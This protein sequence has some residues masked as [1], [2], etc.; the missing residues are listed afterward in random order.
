LAKRCV[1]RAGALRR[2]IR[3]NPTAAQAVKAYTLVR[4]RPLPASALVETLPLPDG[5]AIAS[6]S[7]VETVPTTANN[8]RPIDDEQLLALL[9]PRSAALI[10]EGPDSER[11]I[12]VNPADRDGVPAN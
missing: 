1:W 5:A 9:A 12:F 2:P 7:L 8:Y 11:L 6:A 3:L 4:S 10:R